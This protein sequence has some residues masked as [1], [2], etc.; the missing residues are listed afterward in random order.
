VPRPKKV[1]TILAF[2]SRMLKIARM[3]VRSCA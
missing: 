1:Y 3:F 2:M